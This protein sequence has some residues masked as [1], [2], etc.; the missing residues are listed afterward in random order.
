M[1]ISYLVLTLAYYNNSFNGRSIPWMS[2]ALFNDEGGS[3]NQTAILTPENNVDHSKLATVGLP[4]YTTT[5]VISQMC[6]NFSLGA[7]IVHVLLWHWPD[8]KRAFGG[9]RF[10]KSNQ[11]IDDPHFQGECRRRCI[12][13]IDILTSLC[14]DEEVQGSAAVVVHA[15]L[16]R[17]SGDWYRLQRMSFSSLQLRFR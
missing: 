16:R 10:L 14:R 2:Q 15:S 8:L 5:Y 9:M 17:F 11:D 6:Y 13:L 3:Y 4:R 12:F 1:A 7:A